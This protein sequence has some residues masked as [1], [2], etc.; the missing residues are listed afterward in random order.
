VNIKKTKKRGINNNSIKKKTHTLLNLEKG[1]LKDIFFP[2]G[3][4]EVLNT[5]E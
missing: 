2:Y 5:G 1:V 3:I 4:N